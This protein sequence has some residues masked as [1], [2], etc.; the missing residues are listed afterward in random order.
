MRACSH[1]WQNETKRARWWAWKSCLHFHYRLWM[2]IKSGA[3]LLTVPY[4]SLLSRRCCAALNVAE[5]CSKTCTVFCCSGY[6]PDCIQQL[7]CR[8]HWSDRIWKTWILSD[9]YE[10][11]HEQNSAIYPCWYVVHDPDHRQVLQWSLRCAY[12]L[13]ENCCHNSSWQR[14]ELRVRATYNNRRKSVWQMTQ[15]NIIVFLRLLLGAS[16]RL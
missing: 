3:Q 13:S 12:L 9:S 6:W 16:G 7:L 15:V 10:A 4:L 14:S 2:R 8:L 5:L 11:T 1:C